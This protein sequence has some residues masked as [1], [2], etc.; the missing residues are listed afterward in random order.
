[1]RTKHDVWTRF[2]DQQTMRARQL[3]ASRINYVKCPTT[4]RSIH[5]RLQI[6]EKEQKK[7]GKRSE[8]E[9]KHP[10]H[11]HMC[12]RLKVAKQPNDGRSVN[13]VHKNRIRDSFCKDPAGIGQRKTGLSETSRER[14]KSAPYLRLK[15]SKRTS[16]CQVFSST[17]PA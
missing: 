6:I 5:R 3:F 10:I 13:H 16:K 17:V 1:M 11:E 14:P 15:N 9:H 2:Y 7:L 12:E 4:N 8:R